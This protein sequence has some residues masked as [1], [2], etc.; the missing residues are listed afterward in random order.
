MSSVIESAVHGPTASI[1]QH[2]RGKIPGCARNRWHPPQPPAAGLCL[3]IHYDIKHGSYM[4][5]SMMGNDFFGDNCFF[6]AVCVGTH[7]QPGF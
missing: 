6:M 3:L 2:T 4:R 1:P 7:L 5:N